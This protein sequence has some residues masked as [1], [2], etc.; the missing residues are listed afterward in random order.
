MKKWARKEAK[1]S[2]SHPPDP[3]DTRTGPDKQEY[4]RNEEPKVLEPNTVPGTSTDP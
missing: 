4:H 1:G 2:G 3:G